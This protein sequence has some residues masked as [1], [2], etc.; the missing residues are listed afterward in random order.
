MKETS[1]R[2]SWGGRKRAQA[3]SDLFVIFI[4]AFTRLLLGYSLISELFSLFSFY[5]YFF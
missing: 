2:N 5:F 4:A 1:G 3:K